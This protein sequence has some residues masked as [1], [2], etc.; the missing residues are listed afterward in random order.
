[1][2][3]LS[4]IK[5]VLRKYV[6]RRISEHPIDQPV[7]Y[8]EFGYEASQGGLFCLFL[9]TRTDA[10]PDGTWTIRLEGNSIDMPDWPKLSERIGDTFCVELGETIRNLAIEM[11]DQGGFDDLPK[12]AG[13]E[14]GVE[15]MH[16]IYGWPAWEDRR[17]ENLA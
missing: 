1:M 2:T 14:F 16:G 15:E 3:E 7:K 12:A 9:D 13:C 5:S 17:K 10:G 4:A 6:L 11:R 8:I